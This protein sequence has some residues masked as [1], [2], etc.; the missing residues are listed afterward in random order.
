VAPR[1]STWN[2][3]RRDMYLTQRAMGTMS[4]A[5]RGPVPLAKRLARRKVTRTLMRRLWGN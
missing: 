3:V 5:A 4:A 2:Q 1:R